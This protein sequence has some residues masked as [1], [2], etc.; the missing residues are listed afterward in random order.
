MDQHMRLI[1][2]AAEI[3]IRIP[4]GDGGDAYRTPS[5][6]QRPVA[7][8]PPGL[9]ILLYETFDFQVSAGFTSIVRG[10]SR[11]GYTP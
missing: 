10:I 1:G 2:H 4:A 5:L 8:S 9:V 7:D 3:T 6:P 11:P